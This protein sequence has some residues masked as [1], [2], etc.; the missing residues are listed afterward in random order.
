ME[1]VK[2]QRG[3]AKP[4]FEVFSYTKKKETKSTIRATKREL[5]WNRIYKLLL[6]LIQL[7]SD[8]YSLLLGLIQLSSGIYRLILGLIQL[9]YLQSTSGLDTARVSTVYFWA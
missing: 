1:F 5:Q 2:S 3:A 8:I 4:C 7:S 9:R 6:G